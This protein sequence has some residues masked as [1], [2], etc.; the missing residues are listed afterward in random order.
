MRGWS[1]RTRRWRRSWS[2][3]SPCTRSWTTSSW[4]RQRSLFVCLCLL[5]PCTHILHDLRLFATAVHVIVKLII[6][7]RCEGK[8]FP[9]DAHALKEDFKQKK[10]SESNGAVLI[11]LRPSSRRCYGDKTHVQRFAL[12][13]GTQCFFSQCMSTSFQHCPALCS[14]SAWEKKKSHVDTDPYRSLMISDRCLKMMLLKP[15]P[16]AVW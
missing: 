14:A 15:T 9:F 12:S 1:V 3:P 16:V 13:L 8:D 7:T 2:W 11:I 6:H 5:M 4:Q 10:E